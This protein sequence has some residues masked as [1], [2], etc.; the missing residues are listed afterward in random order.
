MKTKLSIAIAAALV[1][2][3]AMASTSY[4]SN[5][6]S[7]EITSAA[8]Y[9]K[10]E[11]VINHAAPQRFIVEL[12]S[13]SL[14]KYSGGISK[15]SA[16]S[17]VKKGQKINVQSSA[18]KTYSSHLAQEQS[19]FVTALSSVSA[20]SKVER[21]F[22]TLF[23]GVTIVG[24][25]L[26]IEQ[27]MAI[28][29]VKS[30]YPETMYEMSMDASHEVINSKAM[31]DAVAGMENA[32]KGIRV[33]VIDGGIRPENPMFSGDGFAAPEGAMPTD[34]Y[35][36]TVDTTF[37]NNKLIVARWSQPTFQVC[38]DEYMSPLGFGGHGT[39]V[40]GTAVGNKVN[41]TFKD[42]DVELS[43]VAPAAYL[44]SYKALYTKADCSRGSGS[45][46][47]LME[48]LEH[49]V[50]DGADVINN[51]WG[52]GAG[53]DPANS[54]YKTMFEAAEA[55]GVIVVSAAGND[56]NGAKTIGCPACIESG[57]T[58]AN[59]TTGRFFANSF[60]AGEDDLLA[61][62]ANNSA[63][64]TDIS[65]PIIAATNLDAD[66]FEGCSA[67][68]ADSF[69][70]G[71]ALISRGACNFSLKAENALAAG[72]KAMVVY[73]SKAGSPISMFM[74]DATLPSVMIS[75]ADGTAIIESLGDEAT[76]GKIS[77]EVQRRVSKS[78]ADTIN[79]DSSRGPNGNENVLK[80]D[81]AA[82]GT[83]ILS[84]FS[85]DDG[86]E[87]FNMISGTSMASP[88]VAGAAAMMRQLHP[89]WSAN[90]IKTALTSTAMMEGILDDDA[91][92]PASP[93]AMGAGRMDLDAAAKAILTFDR[94]SISAD[95][96]VGKCTFTR[97]VYNKSDEATSW[98]LSASTDS[99]GIT[100][101]P[102]SIELEAGASAE[103]SITVDSTFSEYGSWIFGNV[104]LKSD[105]GKQDAHLPLAV[106]SKES[107]D[108]SLLSISSNATDI[109]ASDAFPIKT[110]I[111]NSI[112]ENTV[113]VSAY[114]P[115]GTSFTSKDDVTVSL[116][117]AQQNGFN[118][119]QDLGLITW[120]GKLDLPEM[121]SSK[122]TGTNPSIF[123]LNLAYVPACDEGCDEKSFN[124]NTL[125]SFKYNG[126]TYNGITIS[127]NGIVIVGT[128]S[129]SGTW[130][131][132]ELPDSANPDNIL[133]PFWTD[134][135][136]TDGTTGDTGGGQL[137]LQVV[138]SGDDSWIVVEW[139]K[140]QVY[141]DTS[142]NTYTFSVWIKT[143]EE[144]DISFHYHDIPNMPAKVTIGAEN[145]GGSVGTTYHH[146]GEGESVT[147]ND[148]ITLQ[149][150]AAGSIE[151]DYSVKATTFNPG[152]TDSATVEEEASVEFNVLDNDLGDQKVARSSVTGDGVTAKAQRLIDVS[153]VGKL[154]KATVVDAPSNG[155]VSLNEDGTAIYTPNKDF[156][157]MDSFTYYSEDEDGNKNGVTKATITVTNINDAPTI[158]P[159]GM[160]S[161]EGF[162]VTAKANGKDI[163][164][165]PLTYIWTQTSGS[166]VVFTNGGP[167]IS[168][169]AP[170]GTHNLTFSVVASDGKLSSEVGF[171]TISVTAKE[172]KSSG[173]TLGWLAM[174]LLP[175]AGLRRR[176]R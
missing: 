56:G 59:S 113:T 117:G 158:S 77:A 5:P 148:F 63:I 29:G 142:G 14:S 147:T 100:V 105:D 106:K 95:S 132:K 175:F 173:G 92:T 80:P 108:A 114:A 145:I 71:I 35:C 21:K 19:K 149:N 96:C 87:D 159:S 119:N 110:T 50:N 27:L 84:A 86:G 40:A 103:L 70:D 34:D 127:D 150:T 58:V 174:L 141:A 36:S 101:S 93:F 54:P 75:Q 44:M 24:Q 171:A 47:M 107:S 163:E 172:D 53:G 11:S 68:A 154:A 28:P 122:S 37:C 46:I 136:L 52:G 102:A 99:A 79:A 135:D 26:S 121:N 130:N 23:N 69:K 62:E 129:A 128:G 42:I 151:I 162:V 118:V 43:G 98:T 33:A 1:S 152:H 22:Q 6:Y 39:H 3:A 67:F 17:P 168:F 51:S 111:N 10:A 166:S 25:G 161:T 9:K 137:G 7:P 89:D 169:T 170:A 112:F 2:S 146:N 124:F 125:P 57:I 133:A 74:P 72:A 12:E 167:S 131:N 49:A 31:W 134:Y 82:P 115:K 61:I 48:A 126:A 66:N 138:T 41:A 30:V 143:G 76:A 123:D 78:L 144:E 32:G 18:A 165:D 156:F 38:P 73:S 116:N 164:N 81:L 60:N 13:P 8:S 176:K 109:E 91:E 15:L 90:D 45:N 4:T 155:E 83:N 104:M 120:V 140:A 153:P 65:A 16:T 55:A 97:T 85:P 64:T 139:N 94:P 157:G 160:T 88:H 20:N